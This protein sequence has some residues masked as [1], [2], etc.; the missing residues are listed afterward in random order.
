VDGAGGTNLADGLL[1]IADQI[2]E[3]L[4]QLVGV[5]NNRRQT[6]GRLEVDLNGITAQ[7]MLVE[8]EGAIEDGVEI[9]SFLLRGGGTRKFEEVLND[10][11]SATGLAMGHFQLAFG[12]IV[13]AS[14]IT[15]EFAGTQ[16]GGERIV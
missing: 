9:Q 1:R 13:N 5:T 16:N 8:L 4:D 12:V 11:G 15:Q 2:E 14:A 3:D 10:A 6:R 7:R